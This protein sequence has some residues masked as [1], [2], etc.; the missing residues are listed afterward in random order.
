MV[1]RH[2]TQA[3]ADLGARKQQRQRNHHHGRDDAGRDVELA[4]EHAG[5]VHDPVDRLVAD[6]EI[7]VS[8]IHAPGE[9]RDTLVAMQRAGSQT[10]RDLAATRALLQQV[11]ASNTLLAQQNY[12]L[13]G[14]LAPNPVVTAPTAPVAAP[15]PAPAATAATGRTHTIATGDTLSKIS[16]RYYGTPNR[17]QEIYNANRAQLGANGTLRVG[18]VLTIP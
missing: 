16:Q 18:G 11:Q 10:E 8:D 4:D 2:R 6:A 17:W 14:A 9:L 3:P 12:Q 5:G 13:K 7:E 15:T 1:V